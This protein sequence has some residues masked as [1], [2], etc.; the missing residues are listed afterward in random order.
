MRTNYLI[1]GIIFPIFL[2][3]QTFNGDILLTS[4]ADVN[5]FPTNFPNIKKVNG[6]VMVGKNDTI[7]LS[8]I[9][10]LSPLASLRYVQTFYIGNNAQL[11]SLA[12]LKIDTVDAL[13]MY[14][15]PVLTT[16]TGL[17]MLKYAYSL[18]IQR[19]EKLPNLQGLNGLL[20]AEQITI[21]FNNQLQTLEGL[22][23]LV[24]CNYYGI[25]V[26]NNPRLKSISGMPKLERAVLKQRQHRAFWQSARFKISRNRHLCE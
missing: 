12:G 19:N 16:L 20:H 25:Y 11:S 1:F 21:N 23:E 24:K 5:L 13:A 14:R 10:D 4:Q 18:T 7:N 6:A 8:D 9:T 3:A 17:N 22:D 26:E 15:N 2:S